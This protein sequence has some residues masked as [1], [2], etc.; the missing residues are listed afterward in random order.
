MTTINPLRYLASVLGDVD[1]ERLRQHAKWGEQNHPDGT[2]P[3]ITP[4]AEIARGKGNAIVNRHYAFG[5][6]LQA[7]SATD[8]AAAEGRVTYRDILFE[9]VFEAIAEDDPAKLE[10]ELIQVAAVAC[11]WVE[12]IRRHREA[13]RS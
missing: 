9:E 13:V 3:H 6:A 5:L 11:A 12:K 8:R 1:S 10:A 7:K 4:V 2:G